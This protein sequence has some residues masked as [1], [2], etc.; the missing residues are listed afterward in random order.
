MEM[1]RQL[2]I[3]NEQ[4]ASLN[5]ETKRL[6]QELNEAVAES[7]SKAATLLSLQK[8]L[9]EKDAALNDIRNKETQIRKIAKKYKSQYEDLTKEMEDEKA[10]S[11]KLSQANKDLAAK[12]YTMTGQLQQSQSECE[13][14]RKIM[15]E[16]DERAKIVLKGART[17]ITQLDDLRKN[18]EKEVADLKSAKAQME[19]RL[20]K[21]EEETF[22]EKQ[23]LLGKIEQLQVHLSSVLSENDGSLQPSNGLKRSISLN[24]NIPESSTI[25]QSN[26]SI[27]QEQSPSPKIKRIKQEVESIIATENGVS[28]V[29]IQASRMNFQIFAVTKTLIVI[30]FLQGETS[31]LDDKAKEDCLVINFEE[32]EME[33]SKD[34]SSER[35]QRV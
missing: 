31:D 7:N 30:I 1:Q 35:V 26:L 9:G 17:K 24:Y 12:I 6:M 29:G 15:L 25:D 5:E 33:T 20:S 4:I 19:T 32:E 13:S 23:I 18:R 14:L 8:D 22:T 11:E 16:K 10:K 2:R 3:Q 21:M 34:D 28:D 27:K